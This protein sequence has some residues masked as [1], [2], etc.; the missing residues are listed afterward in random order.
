M[1]KTS[2]LSL[3]TRNQVI[4]MFRANMKKSA[5]A[6]E[7]G[8]GVSTVHYIISNYLKYG[9]VNS[10]PR[11]GRP[12][13]LGER[14]VRR[15]IQT[16]KKDRK[17][18]IQD[19]HEK[20]SID[21]SKRTIQRK[22]LSLGIRSRSAIRKPFISNVNARKR[23]M[24]CRSYQSWSLKD[25]K[26]VIWSDECVRTLIWTQLEKVQSPPNIGS[27]CPRQL[28]EIASFHYSFIC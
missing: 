4:G 7:M 11:S 8:L 15:L 1:V 25:W 18:T 27:S 20:L 19:I 5:I 6:R 17:A 14:D 10:A 9:S 24:W 28:K 23:L 2:E 16:I 12:S 13:K 3:A 21:A 26:R 22:L